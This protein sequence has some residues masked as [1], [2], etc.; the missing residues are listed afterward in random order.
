MS[1]STGAVGVSG[2]TS[3]EEEAVQVRRKRST[4]PHEIDLELVTSHTMA[5]NKG[6]KVT[7]VHFSGHSLAEPN[8][9]EVQLPCTST[10]TLLALS[11]HM[12]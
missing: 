3:E 8:R 12:R 11:I 7:D 2:R 4:I 10:L 9:Q 5:S 1:T 6:T